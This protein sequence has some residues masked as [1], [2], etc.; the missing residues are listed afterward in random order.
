MVEGASSGRRTRVPG[1]KAPGVSVILPTYNAAEDGGRYLREALDSVASQTR[2][3]LELIVVDDGST[4]ETVDLVQDYF[5]KHPHLRA[6]L[7]QKGNGGQSS[8]RNHGA[9]AA[10]AEW[11]GFIDQD[12]R[13]HAD[14][15]ATVAPYMDTGADLVYTDADTIDEDGVVVHTRIHESRHAGGGHPKQKLSEVLYRDVYVMPGVTLVRRSFF[16]SLGGFD[17]TLSGYEDDDLFVRAFHA[18]RVAYV[19]EATL[20]WRIHGQSSSHTRRM[21]VSGLRYWRKL[22]ERYPVDE[23]GRPTERRIAL[24]FARVFLSYA[25]AQLVAQDELFIENLAAAD[26]VLSH[27]G[28]VDRKAYRLSRWAWMERSFRARCMRSWFLNGL[29]EATR[30]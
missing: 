22:S 23:A 12:D 1:D 7:L 8:A 30:R 29:H 3:D 21:V 15:L 18:G 27:L 9:R 5:S 11:L 25:S 28:S 20:Q 10:S 14:R 26:I 6:Q 2:S 13:W 19:P 24:R 16:L 17:E 4:D